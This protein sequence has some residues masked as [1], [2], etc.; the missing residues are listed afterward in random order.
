[1]WMITSATCRSQARI[2][3]EGCVTGLAS[4]HVKTKTAQDTQI[5]PRNG[6]T[7]Q[8]RP[9]HGFERNG[10]R[11]RDRMI[12]IATLN[13]STIR[14]KEEEIITLMKERNLDI[15]GCCETRIKG[16]GRKSYM[17]TIS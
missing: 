9:R 11:K 15:L 2:K 5:E 3:E 16:E 10:K 8:Q 1:M 14:D 17:K 12:R 6:R 13:V 7:F 4:R